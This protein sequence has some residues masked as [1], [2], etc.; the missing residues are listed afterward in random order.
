VGASGSFGTAGT[1]GQTFNG[2]ANFSA[3]AG[4]QVSIVISEG[5]GNASITIT[6]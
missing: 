4:G 1:A 6:Y 2:A 3:Y 5:A